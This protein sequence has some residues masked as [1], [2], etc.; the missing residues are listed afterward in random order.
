MHEKSIKELIYRAI[1]NGELSIIKQCIALGDDIHVKTER[2]NR[3]VIHL[4]AEYNQLDCLKLFLE[5]GV[6]LHHK[7]IFG[8]TALL[9]SAYNDSLDCLKFLIDAGL[10][11]FEKDKF[12]WNALHHAAGNGSLNCIKHLISI[13]PELLEEKN[14]SG[15]TP[16]MLS[17]AHNQMEAYHYLV[18]FL[19]NK[20]LDKLIVSEKQNNE[21]LGF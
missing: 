20:R 16:V 18:S 21:Y 11:I 12:Q 5:S 17:K 4:C 6:N 8:R 2:D 13:K 1:K 3:T 14:N 7:S 15:S 10:D 9:E 19:E